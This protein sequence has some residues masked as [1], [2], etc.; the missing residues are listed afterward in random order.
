MRGVG[1]TPRFSAEGRVPRTPRVLRGADP[2]PS[3][4]PSNPYF[5]GRPGGS[6]SDP[7]G[8]ARHEEAENRHEAKVLETSVSR[9]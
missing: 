4:S 1:R 7:E 8:R 3:P 2:C 9:C 5:V 6:G